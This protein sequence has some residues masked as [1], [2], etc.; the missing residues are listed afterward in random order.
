MKTTVEKEITEEKLLI[1]NHTDSA[2]TWMKI[3]SMIYKLTTNFD[4]VLVGNENYQM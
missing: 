4:T 3:Y 1:N 2:V